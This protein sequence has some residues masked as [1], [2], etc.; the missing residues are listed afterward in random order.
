M[1]QHYDHCR[2]L[3]RLPHAS[4][5]DER[6]FKSKFL[7]I[8]FLTNIALMGRKFKHGWSSSNSDPFFKKQIK[9]T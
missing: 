2:A 7:H 6:L 8:A 3:E 1:D 9:S 5:Y 4:E